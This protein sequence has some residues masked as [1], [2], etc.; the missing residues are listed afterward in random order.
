MKAQKEQYQRKMESDDIRKKIYK[1]VP[2]KFTAE[3][4]KKNEP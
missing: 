2:V 1:E 3:E 4:N